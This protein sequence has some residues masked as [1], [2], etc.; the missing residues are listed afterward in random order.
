MTAVRSSCALLAGLL[1][2]A[3]GPAALTARAPT[4]RERAAI[5]AALPADIRAIPAECLRLDIR[6]SRNGRYAWVGGTY[7]RGEK[8][9]SRCSAYGRN[10]FSIL[11]RAARR[12]RI[13]YVGS[14]DP[15]CVLRVPRDL[16]GC[17]P[18]DTE[19]DVRLGASIASFTHILRNHGS[20]APVPGPGAQLP[21]SS[22][23]TCAPAARTGSSL[24]VPRPG[25]DSP[26][27]GPAITPRPVVAVAERLNADG[28][29][30]R[31]RAAFSS[32]SVSWHR[33]P[34][35]AIRE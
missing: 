18:L 31:G 33:M 15:P 29:F 10:G 25:P 11:R 9:G 23:F 13:V 20:R 32:N 21:G 27:S 34:A 4:A 12:W 35:W 7:P 14:V 8:R 22:A 5:V 28:L 6:V 16:S 1:G 19:L 2:L 26:A 30:G 17:R 24:T 3:F